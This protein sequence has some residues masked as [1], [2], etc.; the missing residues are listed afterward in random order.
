MKDYRTSSH[1]FNVIWAKTAS[2]D[3]GAIIDYIAVKNNTNAIRVLKKIQKKVSH[4]Y[5]MPERGRIVPELKEFGIFLYREIMF[6]PWRII[7]RISEPDVHVLS[8]I[9]G[10][11]NVE[12]ILFERFIH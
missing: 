2:N 9:D 6:P 10:H 1:K 8:V 7:Y 3:L 5:S 4:L 11:R 12:D